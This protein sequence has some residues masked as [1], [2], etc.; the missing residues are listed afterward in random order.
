MVSLVKKSISDMTQNLYIT[1]GKF[2]DEFIPAKLTNRD[3]MV[4]VGKALSIGYK[5]FS[6]HRHADHVKVVEMRNGDITV[7]WDIVRVLDKAEWNA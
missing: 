6:V 2:I 3:I 5:D 1:D 4:I 7:D